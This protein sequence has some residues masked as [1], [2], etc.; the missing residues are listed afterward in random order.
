M[1]Q[2]AGL[3]PGSS[4]SPPPGL[5]IAGPKAESLAQGQGIADAGVDIQENVP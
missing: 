1:P 4:P 3:L 5:D 2:A